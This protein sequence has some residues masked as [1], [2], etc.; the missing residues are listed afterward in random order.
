MKRKNGERESCSTSILCLDNKEEGNCTLMMRGGLRGVK[1][2]ALYY[3][4]S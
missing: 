4:V 2:V 1:D 3:I